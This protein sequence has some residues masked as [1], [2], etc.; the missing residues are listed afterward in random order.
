MTPRTL[1]IT[2]AAAGVIG[3]A[4]GATIDHELGGDNGTATAATRTVPA[5]TAATNRPAN[6]TGGLDAGAIYD[7]T[8]D[9]V[10]FI[11]SRTSEGVATG[12]GFAISKDGYLVTNAHVVD[13]AT[14]VTVKVG[15]GK[16]VTA[17]VVGVDQSTDIALLKIDVGDTPLATVALGDSSAVAVGDPVF[18]IGNPFGLDRTLTTGVVSALQRS[19]DAPNGFAITN[20]IQTDAALNPG[21]S[22][23]PLLNAQGQVIG[24]NSQI[25]SPTQSATGQGQNSGIG[26]AVPSDTVKRVVQQLRTTGKATHA[27]LGVQLSDATDDGGATVGALTPGGPA[28]KGGLQRGDVITAVGGK[29]IQTSEDLQS[30]VDADTP[31]NTMTLTVKRGGATKTLHVKL[32]TRPASAVSTSAQEQQQQPNFPQGL[33]P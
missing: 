14:R 23:G 27:Y 4:A 15:D 11:T 33:L 28:A 31:G 30:A 20:V 2:V 5:Q 7:R 32:G 19:I 24:V 17:K 1:L 21:N 6:P 8:K 13:G 12:T 29:A 16:T 25:E 9:A 10:A 26:F 3:G 18:A 22:G